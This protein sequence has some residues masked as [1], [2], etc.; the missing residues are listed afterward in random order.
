[1]KLIPALTLT[2]LAAAASAQTAPAAPS[3]KQAISYDR[4]IVNY[5]SVS[6]NDNGADNGVSVFA[7]GS[8]GRGFYVSGSA[9]NLDN[10][11]TSN[12]DNASVSAAFGLAISLPKTLGISTDLNLE[13]GHDTYS[14]GLRSLL[15]GGLEIGLAYGKND[16]TPN[17]TFTVSAVY[18]LNQF[19]KGL[20]LNAS[21]ADE[22]NEG[23]FTSTVGI[24]Y[25][26]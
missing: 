19:V 16:G 20:T 13:V 8:L 12:G 24:G 25:N 2:T 9:T 3:A 4:V 5:V 11:D 1:M 7:Q 15:G 21:Y 10:T 26:F 14:V 23:S 6:G 17:N 22:T 18:S